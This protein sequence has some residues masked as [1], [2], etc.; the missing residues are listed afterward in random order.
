MTNIRLH[1]RNTFKQV[2]KILM[3]Y[4]FE[5]KLYFQPNQQSAVLGNL[6]MAALKFTNYSRGYCSKAK[7]M[8][9]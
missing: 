8:Q 7:G 6:M 9:E 5:P 1:I 2:F 4:E 3:T